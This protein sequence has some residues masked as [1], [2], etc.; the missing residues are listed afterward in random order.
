M[1]P[2]VLPFVLVFCSRRIKQFVATLAITNVSSGF[3]ADQLGALNGRLLNNRLNL[4]EAAV[5]KLDDMTEQA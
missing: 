2:A 3:Y 4:K 1:L 5:S